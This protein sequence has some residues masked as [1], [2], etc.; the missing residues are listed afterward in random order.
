MTV[1]SSY[2]CN[3]VVLLHRFIFL[4]AVVFDVFFQYFYFVATWFESGFWVGWFLIFYFL[5][6]L[7]K[8]KLIQINLYILVWI[9]MIL[10]IFRFIKRI[11]IKSK[12]ILLHSITTLYLSSISIYVLLIL[13]QV[14]FLV[15]LR[16]HIFIIILNL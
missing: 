6:R 13:F 11:I 12:S 9:I 4:F 7:I 15:I 5:V 14:Y 8:A 16:I 2:G 10:N 1:L 3:F